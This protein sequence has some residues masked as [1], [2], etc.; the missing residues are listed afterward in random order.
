MFVIS[1]DNVGSKWISEVSLCGEL[2]SSTLILT[3]SLPMVNILWFSCKDTGRLLCL[4]NL[5]VPLFSYVKPTGMLQTTK[6]VHLKP[7]HMLIFLNRSMG[8]ILEA[9][10]M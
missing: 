9:M 8:M 4:L 1:S 7:R 10:T 5:L 2:F 6:R 3:D